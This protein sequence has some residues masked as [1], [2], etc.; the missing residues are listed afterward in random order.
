MKIIAEIVEAYHWTCPS[1]GEEHVTWKD[2][3]DK[4]RQA[5]SLPH[6]PVECGVCGCDFKL[7]VKGK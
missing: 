7:S 6:I 4:L 3:I 1:C 5:Y 2:P